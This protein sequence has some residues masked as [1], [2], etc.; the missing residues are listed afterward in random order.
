MN[1]LALS[2]DYVLRAGAFDPEDYGVLRK[3]HT[4]EEIRM[5]ALKRYDAL[6]QVGPERLVSGS[7]DF[8]LFLWIPHTDKKHVGNYSHTLPIHFHFRTK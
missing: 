6:L 3:T 4:L 1:S 5:N 2:T 7:D 8:T